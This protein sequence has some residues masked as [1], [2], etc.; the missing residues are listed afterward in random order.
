MIEM[1]LSKLNSL[2]YAKS[3]PSI[4]IVY[5]YSK[6]DEYIS[7]Q[8]SLTMYEALPSHYKCFAE[9]GVKHNQSRP[10]E[11][12]KFV[13]FRIQS[14]MIKRKKKLEKLKLIRKKKVK[15]SILNDDQQIDLHSKFE[16]LQKRNKSCYNL[17]VRKEEPF[18]KITL[19]K[20][21]VEKS[22]LRNLNDQRI[23]T[24]VLNYQ[25]KIKQNEL[26]LKSIFARDS[27]N[28]KRDSNQT[29]TRASNTTKNSFN[30]SKNIHP[31]SA[32]ILS[33]V[34]LHKQPYISSQNI[35][36]SPHYRRMKNIAPHPKKSPSTNIYKDRNNIKRLINKKVPP[37]KKDFVG[38]ETSL[39]S[40]L[41]YLKIKI[42]NNFK[43][44]RR[45]VSPSNCHSFNVSAQ[46]NRI[47]TT[48]NTSQ[49]K[50]LSVLKK[51]YLYNQS[52]HKT[53]TS[54]YFTQSG[55]SNNTPV[56]YQSNHSEKILYSQQNN[57]FFEPNKEYK[58]IYK[59]KFSKNILKEFH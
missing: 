26:S 19:N 56:Y 55:S 24:K 33:P 29:Q 11:T 47:Y 14:I 34:L 25:K 13:F 17:K 57:I 53:L 8:D 35:T 38:S 41:K 3:F 9:C 6:T 2:T 23:K 21:R 51:A 27:Q 32:Q 52:Q 44:R 20:M 37:V 30:S 45:P 42:D 10:N 7:L 5:I 31:I 28:S 54:N 12:I 48:R 46:D 22:P 16:N 39:Q 18:P 4:P 1:D 58:N 15:K 49:S 40:K 50:P 59:Q 43:Q 36:N